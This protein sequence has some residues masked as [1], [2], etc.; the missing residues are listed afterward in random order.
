VA[1]FEQIAQ[2]VKDLPLDMD[3]RPVPAQFEAGRIQLAGTERIHAVAPG[4]ALA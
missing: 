2:H 3:R 1:V 4:F